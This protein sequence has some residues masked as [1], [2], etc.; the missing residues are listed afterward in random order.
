MRYFQATEEHTEQVVT[1]VQD[2]IKEAYPKYYPNEIVDFFCELHNSEK[3]KN[4][5]KN[6]NVWL[7]FCDNRLVGTGCGIENH[8]TRVYV[9]PSF[10]R[11]G[12]GSYIMQQLEDEI[13][14]RYSEAVL[15][16][17]LPASRLYEKRGYKTVKHENLV[18]KNG[19]VLVYE[20]MK[21]ELPQA[22]TAISYSGKSFIPKANTANG[23]TDNRTIFS[24]HQKGDI[25][26][27]EYSGGDIIKGHLLG[28]AEQNGELDFHYQHININKQVRI[29]KCHSVPHILDSG[30][31]ELHEEWQWL[32]GDKSS[33]VSVVVEQ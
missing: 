24:Y 6:R 17:S 30:K 33:G 7:L 20:V 1:L 29:G 12:H 18:V 8:I 16:A 32:N 2:T 11:N 4:D 10:Q 3:I 19:V 14:K 27:A 26:S 22:T 15:D 9:L 5:I 28:T 31:L 21:K 23:E 25:I 13:G